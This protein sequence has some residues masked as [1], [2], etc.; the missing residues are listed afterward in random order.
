MQIFRII[1]FIKYFVTHLKNK[2]NKMY[3]YSHNYVF[4]QNTLS[5]FNTL[6]LFTFIDVIVFLFRG[7]LAVFVWDWRG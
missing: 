6:H 4:I 7:N 3:F 1:P 5:F 2:K